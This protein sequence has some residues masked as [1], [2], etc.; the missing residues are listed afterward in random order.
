MNIVPGSGS[1]IGPQLINHPEIAKVSFTGGNEVG[2]G[3]MKQAADTMKNISLELGGKSPI[4]VFPDADINGAIESVITGIFYNTGQ[5]CSATSRLIVHKSI[6]KEFYEILKRETESLTLGAGLDSGTLMGPLTT[7]GQFKTVKKYIDIA[8][9]EGLECLTG[10]S[11]VDGPGNFI[12]PTIFTNVPTTSQLWKDEIFGPVLVTRSF[13]TEQEAISLANDTRF[14]L[15][16]AVC[17][18]DAEQLQRV[19]ARLQAGHIWRNTLQMVPAET[20]WGGFKHSGIGREL[21]PF[22]LSSFLEV[23]HVDLP[24]NEIAH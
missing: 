11:E 17:G 15:A 12:T 2:V 13:E 20:S 14:G 24:L 4:I 9:E 19:C 7:I 22:G 10:G 23:K 8:K 16:A 21:G 3:V 6:E 18:Q 1:K 5:M